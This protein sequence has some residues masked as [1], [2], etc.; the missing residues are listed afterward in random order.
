MDRSEHD[1]AR[2]FLK[3]I[4]KEKLSPAE[5]ALLKEY[6]TAS[7][8]N[9]RKFIALTKKHGLQD[10]LQ[11][12][13]KN[14]D[15]SEDTVWKLVQDKLRAGVHYKN[16]ETP[17]IPTRGRSFTWVRWAAAAMVIVMTG[18]LAWFLTA[19]KSG[20][21]TIKPLA[22]NQVNEVLPGS[23]RAILT[24]GDGSTVVLDNAHNGQIGRQGAVTISKL[25]NGQLAYSKGEVDGSAVVYNTLTTPRAG[26]YEVVLP[27][28]T[29]VWLN[30]ASSL[31]YPASFTGAERRVTVSGEGYFEV[32]KDKAHPFKVVVHK[33]QEED[34]LIEVLGTNF[35][36]NAYPDENL[37]KT[38]LLEGS[39]KFIKNG[40]AALVKPGQQVN[41]GDKGQAKVLSGIDTDEVIAWK[42]GYF[43]F[44][45]ADVPTVMRQLARWY[46]VDIQYEGAVPAKTFRGK[47]GRNLPLAD[48][49]EVLKTNQLHCIIAGKKLIVKPE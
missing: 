23:D 40:A 31:R 2:L 22:Q 36:I 4:S 1:M 21:D 25:G 3:F 33:P 41:T 11:E 19:K 17:I 49:L 48:V 15:E 47:I 39:I 8:A 5:T 10:R 42:N 12:F 38:T 29:K 20:T 30:N 43:H 46:D 13:S 14:I 6:L 34:A 26:Q 35:N 18:S 16:E 37:Q 27:D 45:D 44:A 24:L 28:G 32:A 9:R 7:M